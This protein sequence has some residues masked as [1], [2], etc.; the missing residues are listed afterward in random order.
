MFLCPRKIAVIGGTQLAA[1]AKGRLVAPSTSPSPEKVVLVVLSRAGGTKEPTELNE[2]SSIELQVLTDVDDEA[3]P[4][5]TTAAL[6]AARAKGSRGRSAGAAGEQARRAEKLRPDG[7][8]EVSAEP[9]AKD[10]EQR[11]EGSEWLDFSS[12]GACATR[13]GDSAR[14]G[15]KGPVAC[16]GEGTRIKA[17]TW[18]PCDEPCRQLACKLWKLKPSLVTEQS[19]GGTLITEPFKL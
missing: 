5:C 16:C 8:A 13:D 11:V 7:A 2:P 19:S 9:P 1:C 15:T 3:C 18:S 10:V 4:A 14:R 6:A 12:G 17:G